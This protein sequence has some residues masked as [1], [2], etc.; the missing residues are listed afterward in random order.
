VH[1]NAQQFAE[2]PDHGE[3]QD[4]LVIEHFAHSPFIAILIG[5]LPTKNINISRAL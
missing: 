5:N 2:S 3:G 1:G 4:L